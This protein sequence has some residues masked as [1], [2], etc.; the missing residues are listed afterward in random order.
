MW[1]EA[2]AL[3]GVKYNVGHLGRSFRQ[4]EKK[5]KKKKISVD[6]IAVDLANLRTHGGC[7]FLT[8]N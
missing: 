6:A 3:R 7:I 1:H 8:K 5:K 2:H 4:P